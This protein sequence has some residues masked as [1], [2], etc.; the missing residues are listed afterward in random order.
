MNSIEIKTTQFIEE[1]DLIKEG[2]N[3]LLSLSAGKDSI[4]ML[5]ILR[6]YSDEKNFKIGIFHLNHLLRGKDSDR[7]AEFI[8]EIA[9]SYNIPSHSHCFDFINNPQKR[10]S[11]E[12]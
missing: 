4:A 7:D 9:D 12:E 11:F 2:D 8:S 5:N 1:K 6:K 10:M 3:I